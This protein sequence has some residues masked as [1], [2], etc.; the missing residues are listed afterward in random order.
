[1]KRIDGRAEKLES[2]QRQLSRDF[3]SRRL[4]ILNGETA[5]ILEQSALLTATLTPVVN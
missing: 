3:V 4:T 5:E 2:A 1:V